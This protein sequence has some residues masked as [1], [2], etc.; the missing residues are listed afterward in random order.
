MGILQW[1]CRCF[2]HEMLGLRR[3]QA[4]LLHWTL[5]L[6]DVNN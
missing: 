1:Q 3:E 4:T 6:I 2:R 5:K